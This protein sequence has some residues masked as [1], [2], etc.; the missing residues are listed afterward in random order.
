MKKR[1]FGGGIFIVP[2]LFFAFFLFSCADSSPEL[3]EV[4][5]YLVL[6]FEE[7]KALSDSFLSVFVKMP[8]DSRRAESFVVKSLDD[9]HKIGWK[10]EEPGVFDVDGEE[11]VYALRLCHQENQQLPKGK[12]TLFY[13]DAGGQ[14]V[15]IDFDFSYEDALIFS[16]KDDISSLI[17]QKTENLA[18]YDENNALIFFGKA[19]TAWKTDSDIKKDMKTAESKRI[20]LYSKDSQIIVLFPVEKLEDSEE[21]NE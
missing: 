3:S 9:K 21:K 15:E 7:Q 18:L 20:V 13:K 19:K 14:E 1:F 2:V 17:A 10:I 11:F 6:E 5:P 8:H 4:N 16:S 12:F